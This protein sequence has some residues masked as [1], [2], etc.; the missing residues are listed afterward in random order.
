MIC[1]SA[2]KSSIIK[3]A[4]TTDIHRPNT[5]ENRLLLTVWHNKNYFFLPHKTVLIMTKK[6]FKM[7]KN[8]FCT[9][10]NG[11]MIMFISHIFSPSSRCLQNATIWLEIGF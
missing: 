6:N 4:E 8:Q 3:F 5:S 1:I 9:I 7:P 11:L 2:M 10:R